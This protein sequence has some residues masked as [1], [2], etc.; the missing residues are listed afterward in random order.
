M[1]YRE[2][3][4]KLKELKALGFTHVR[5]NLPKPAL[6]IEYDRILGQ[7]DEL[8]RQEK[9]IARRDARAS[10]LR[11]ELRK[12]REKG[13]MDVCLNAT[14]EELEIAYQEALENKAKL[15]QTN[16]QNTGV[17]GFTHKKEFMLTISDSMRNYAKKKKTYDR[18][19]LG[20]CAAVASVMSFETH[21]TIYIFYNA[22][23][24]YVTDDIKEEVN[25]INDYY[26]VE[27]DQLYRM[28]SELI[29]A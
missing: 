20:R 22:N 7:M 23:G 28:V 12:L 26:Q 14:L 15:Q 21:Q 4:L 29:Y 2:L 17:V 11:T 25:Y 27:E 13:Y 10:Y 8:T 6:Q 18:N 1:T 16:S 3:Q 5:V 19:S 9:G 24:Y